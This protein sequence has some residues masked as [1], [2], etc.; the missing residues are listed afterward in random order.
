MF[1]KDGDEDE[2]DE[3]EDEAGPPEGYEEEEDDDED[4]AGS[5][6]GEGEEEVGLSYLMKDEIQV[7]G[8]L[9]FA[10]KTVGPGL[11]AV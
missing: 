6:V 5:E 7:N 4:E 10:L 11:S 8:N 9:L 1:S 3:D 2:E